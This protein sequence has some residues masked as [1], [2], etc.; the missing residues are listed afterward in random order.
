MIACVPEQN[1]ISLRGQAS[2]EYL[3]RRLEGKIR[4]HISWRN[5]SRHNSKRSEGAF[6]TGSGTVEVFKDK[7]P[8][9]IMKRHRAKNERYST[10]FVL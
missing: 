4:E 9:T 5:R 2:L 10:A 3:S 8:D 6:G 1:I 7:G